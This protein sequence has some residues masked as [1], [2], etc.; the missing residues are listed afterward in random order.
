MLAV[1]H[2]V[3]HPDTERPGDIDAVWL[4]GYGWPSWRGG[5]MYHA[6]RIGVAELHRRLKA[7]EAAHGERFAPAP[8]LTRMAAEGRPF[9]AEGK[10]G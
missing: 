5:P 7:L 2:D 1:F 9:F 3:G 6:D 4:Q 10:E 8:L